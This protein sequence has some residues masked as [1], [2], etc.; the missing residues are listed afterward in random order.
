MS[1][2]SGEILKSSVRQGR[3][4]KARQ[5]RCALVG[6]IPICR[7]QVPL[8]PVRGRVAQSLWNRVTAQQDRI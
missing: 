4:P 2:R 7:G 8:G 6:E 5:M 1:S 3:S